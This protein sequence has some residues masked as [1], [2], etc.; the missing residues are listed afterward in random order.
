M[1]IGFT[2]SQICNISIWSFILGCITTLIVVSLIM[3]EEINNDK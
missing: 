2:I 3:K 1:I